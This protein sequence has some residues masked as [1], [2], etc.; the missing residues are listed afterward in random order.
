MSADYATNP[1]LNTLRDYLRIRSVHPNVNYDECLT[2]LRGQAAAIGLP[3]QVFEVV[4]KKPVLVMTWEGLQPD[5]P[6]ILLNSHMDVVPVFEKSWKHPPFAAEIVDG[7]IYGRGVQDMKSVAV[8]YLEA[9]RRLKN[10]G[11][12]LKRTVHLSFVPDEEVGGAKGMAEFVKTDHY[13]N[14]R[15]GF[16]LDEG[17]ACATEEYQVFNGE[18]TIWHLNVVCPGKSGHGSLLLPDTCGEKVRI[19]DGVLEG[20]VTNNG[21]KGKIYSFRG[22]PYAQPPLG[23]LRFKAPQPVK[24]WN[25]VRDAKKLGNE[26]YQ[27]NIFSKTLNQGSE[28]CLYINVFSPNLKP[29]NPLPVMVWIHGGGFTCGSGTDE[30]YGPDYL[31][32]H[33][34]PKTYPEKDEKEIYEFFKALRFETL[35]K[36]HITVTYAETNKE[37]LFVPFSIV[38]EKQFGDNERFMV[39]EPI[40]VLRNCGIHDGVDVMEGYTE[41]EGVVFLTAG[42]DVYKM[43]SQANKYPEF[44]VPKT[45]SIY[46]PLIDQ[47]E[48][49][50]M[51]KQFYF[52]DE[53]VSMDNLYNLLKYFGAESFKYPTIL[54]QKICAKRGKNNI[55]LYKFTCK[56]EL[57]V[58]KHIMGVEDFILRDKTLVSHGDDLPYIFHIKLLTDINPKI[59]TNSRALKMIDQ[60]TKLWTNF[61][62]YGN[63]TPDESLGVIWKPYTLEGQDFLDIG[64]NLVAGTRP[65]KDEL[66]FWERIYTKYCPKY[67]P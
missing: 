34:T 53:E 41:D 3:V 2:F 21:H 52:K 1:A 28:D 55:F 20:K 36:K 24:P 6:S 38:V 26:C 62:K 16:A 61:A 59:A 32:R 10:K 58:F 64:E 47:M 4:P 8:Q 65:D 51:I 12:R 67:A 5:L 54:F 37:L 22:I 66:E 48:V 9:V 18:R 45:M 42:K 25:G 60:V 23:D 63:P 57:N 39:A 33:D 13:K 29:T 43:I 15:V 56:S 50:K 11:I 17:I 27:Y 19:S 49:G 7:V 30:S 14:L 40:E 35:V 44:L 31:I 46:C